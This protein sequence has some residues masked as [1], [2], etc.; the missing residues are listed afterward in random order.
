[1]TESLK[2][3]NIDKDGKIDYKEFA[4]VCMCMRVYHS[5]I[6]L[7]YM[8]AL[9]VCPSYVL[10]RLYRAVLCLCVHTRTVY[11][12]PHTPSHTLTQT[13]PA[14]PAAPPP[15]D[16]LL[17]YYYRWSAAIST[18]T[19]QDAP[20]RGAGKMIKKNQKAKG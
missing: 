15:V 3:A 4:K 5:T 13:G 11:T 16:G 6:C 10:S 20:K 18:Y 1:M 2:L 7:K 14:S 8:S 17:L 12:R 19:F 9:Y